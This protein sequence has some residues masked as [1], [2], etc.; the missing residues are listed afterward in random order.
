[1][2]V[3]AILNGKR[4]CIRDMGKSRFTSRSYAN[5]ISR[6]VL[7]SVGAGLP[8]LLTLLTFLPGF[9]PLFSILKPYVVY[10]AIIRR[11]HVQPLP[12]LLGNAPTLGQSWY[13]I[14]FLL[15]NIFVT[16][17]DY[18]SFQPNAMFS[19]TKD[20]ILIYVANRTGVLAFALAP[21]VLLFAG[22]NNVLLWLT[23]WSH[24]TYLLLHR[25]IARIFTL[26]VIIHSI[27][28]LEYY[29]SQGT[30]KEE[31]AQAYWI[32]GAVA[33]V[34]SCIMVVISV[35]WFRRAAYEI[36][37]VLH[38]L[39][40]AFVI[41]GCWYHVEL[42]FSRRWGYEQ[43]LYAA[44]AV[45]FF[46]R[47]MRLV[48]IARNG[49]LRAELTEIDDHTVR[50]DV[51][52]PKWGFTPGQ[53]AY[54]YFPGA[55]RWTFW[56]AHPFSVIPLPAST[57]MVAPSIER[58]LQS[59]TTSQSSADCRSSDDE[60]NIGVAT[61][62]AVI[63]GP[64][65]YTGVRFYLRKHSGIT[66]ALNAQKAASVLLE[67]PY[68]NHNP[69]FR[70][71]VATCDRVILFAGGVGITGVLSFA[72]A[73][74]SVKLYWSAKHPSKALVDD[75]QNSRL[76]SHLGE[77]VVLNVGGPRFNFETLLREETSHELKRQKIGVVVCG[78]PS[79]CDDLRAAVVKVGK[80][81]AKRVE[82]TLAEEAFSW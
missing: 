65:H 49:R 33:T 12:Y 51:P 14:M 55:K 53:H 37:L 41:I 36:F 9:S 82:F 48:W 24:S 60:K 21:L 79:F 29:K 77:G 57:E 11:Y 13:I 63:Q 61:S 20:E 7:L 81:E 1:M 5:T 59:S 3:P 4:V 44:C 62:T 31:E 72:L 43:W 80:A 75:V 18:K 25:W 27:A 66:K 64:N 8:V 54:V 23:N 28:E 2:E 10:P 78:P 46:D 40:A 16:A 70:P 38:V 45:W 30:Y 47:V 32:W 73:H 71:N 69:F 34:A 50:I 26:Q 19:S 56:E 17:L 22:R 58:T 42:L 15:L 35:L 6:T 52:G 76:L 74:P 68:Y 67:G 39:L